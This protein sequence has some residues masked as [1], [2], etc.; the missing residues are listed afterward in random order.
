MNLM[1]LT[2]NAARLSAVTGRR[3]EAANGLELIVLNFVDEKPVALGVDTETDQLV[4]CDVP[5]ERLPDIK[6]TIP[7]IGEAYGL[8]L[9]WSWEMKNQQGYFDAVQIE[10]TDESLTKSV[11]LQFK[12]A[13]SAI[14]VFRV[15]E[16]H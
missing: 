4:W 14:R 13:A 8:T 1:S 7:G 16:T 6:E 11:L 5:H 3:L 15:V 10:V 9:T 2:Q 12:V